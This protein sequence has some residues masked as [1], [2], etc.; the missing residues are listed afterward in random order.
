MFLEAKQQFRT[1]A[2]QNPGMSTEQMAS[3][4]LSH[5]TAEHSEA[6]NPLSINP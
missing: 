3:V 2:L 4:W 1:A 5:S 6:H